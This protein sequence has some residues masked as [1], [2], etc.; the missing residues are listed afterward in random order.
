MAIT[1]GSGIA[2]GAGV[3]LTA[4]PPSIVTEG[5]VLYYDFSDPVSYSGSGTSVTDLSASNNTGTVV[6]DYSAISYVADAQ[7][8]YFNWSTDVGGSGSNSFGGSIHTAATNTYQDFTMVFQPDFTVSGMAGL[9][10]IPGDKSLRF[11]NAVWQAPNP[12]N[13]DDWAAGSGGATTFYING[14][15]SNQAVAGWNIM[16][17]ATTNSSFSGPTQLYIG[18]SGYENRN[19]QGKI[20]VVLMYDRTLTAEE[21]LQNFNYYKLRFDL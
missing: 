19:M 10:G 7:T 18:T 2:V 5:L 20:A 13:D 17:G 15:A 3:S 6:N 11:Y 14:Q 8:S 9:F 12:G 1:I 4:P 16:G 21:Q